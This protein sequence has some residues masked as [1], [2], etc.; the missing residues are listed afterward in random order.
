MKKFPADKR[1]PKVP[2]GLKK[3]PKVSLVYKKSQQ[4]INVTKA[5][6]LTIGY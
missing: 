4:L 2:L 6:E 1:S 3:L 5:Q